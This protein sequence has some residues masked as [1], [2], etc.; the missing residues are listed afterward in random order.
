MLKWKW[1]DIK[2]PFCLW[3]TVLLLLVKGRALWSH[4]AK[5]F[6]NCN[7]NTMQKDAPF[8]E[9]FKKKNQPSK[10]TFALLNLH[11]Q[12]PSWRNYALVYTS[13]VT[14]MSCLCC[15]YTFNSSHW[16]RMTTSTC[17]LTA[18][19][20]KSTTK[21][22]HQ[23]AWKVKMPQTSRKH[24][25]ETWVLIRREQTLEPSMGEPRSRRGEQTP[26]AARKG[27]SARSVISSLQSWLLNPFKKIFQS[28][29]PL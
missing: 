6:L 25:F 9:C 24:L 27:S 4:F 17:I 18:T 12:L 23:S 21:S 20:L 1:M 15:A 10:L 2:E 13:L 29:H 8:Y 22:K 7:K 14:T 5:S 11:K 19:V 3:I 26:P 16:P 28:S